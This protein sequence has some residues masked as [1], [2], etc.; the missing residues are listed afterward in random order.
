MLRRKY[1]T[2]SDAE[3]SEREEKRLVK[4]A[5]KKKP[6]RKDTKRNR[7]KDRDNSEKDSD[8][9]QDKKDRSQN[10]KDAQERVVEKYLSRSAVRRVLS[11]ETEKI[12]VK[13]K[14]DGK[15]VQVSEK[16][17]SEESGKYEEIDPEVDETEVDEEP[18]PTEEEKEL[19]EQK[20]KKE[21]REQ[22]KK[23]N[24]ANSLK[25]KFPDVELEEI[26]EVV[27]GKETKEELAELEKMVEEREQEILKDDPKKKTDKILRDTL[28]GVPEY[29]VDQAMKEVLE[30]LE[31]APED[32]DNATSEDLDEIQAQLNSIKRDIDKGVFDLDQTMKTDISD[33]KDAFAETLSPQDIEEAFQSL[34]KGTKEDFR[35]VRRELEKREKKEEKLRQKI[36][37]LEQ[38]KLKNMTQKERDKKKKELEDKKETL[39]RDQYN[40]LVSIAEFEKFL[41]D[42]LERVT[43]LPEEGEEPQDMVKH[44]EAVRARGMSTFENYKNSDSE[45]INSNIRRLKEAIKDMDPGDA[46]TQEVMAMI[47]GLK[48]AEVYAKGQEGKSEETKGVGSATAQIIEWALREG[49]DGLEDLI[50]AEV[51]GSQDP[52]NAKAQQLIH[53]QLQKVV[54]GQWVDL[55]PEDHPA[56]S[57][58]E[59]LADDDPEG[60]GRFLSEQDREWIRQQIQYV[61]GSEIAFADPASVKDDPEAKLGDRNKARAN[62]TGGLVAP[63]PSNYDADQMDQFRADTEK[64]RQDFERA[65]TEPFR[66]MGNENIIDF[67]AE[68][69]RRRKEQEA[70]ME[71]QR[72]EREKAME[73]S[74]GRMARNNFSINSL[75]TNLNDNNTYLG[76]QI[77]RKMSKRQARDFTRAMDEMAT[78]IQKMAR[79]MGIPS[80]VA[81][82]FALRA[83]MISDAI[84]KNANFDA[85]T[86]GE[87]VPGPLEMLDS[88]EPWMD[89]HFTGINGEE[90]YNV[91]ESGGFS[92]AKAAS[93][94]R[95]AR[96]QSKG[97]LAGYEA[98]EDGLEPTRAEKRDPDF[99]EGYNAAKFEQLGQQ[100]FASRRSRRA[101]TSRRRSYRTRR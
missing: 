86:I 71:R 21:E 16:T 23:E 6:P 85:S 9:D 67:Q 72:A 33:L 99:M 34:G 5:P 73:E 8:K 63:D 48:V 56:R 22:K 96:I 77:M 98:F 68:A 26:L 65:V 76:D 39:S 45:T 46:R 42:P 84:E 37:K 11:K 31:I 75:Y 91:Q 87:V 93:R 20:R 62:A 2:L 38:D 69:E 27:T 51:A 78:T 57:L 47:S 53:N 92:N 15:V 101:S 10:F 43:D 28:K 80:K 17:L 74:S 83:D 59:L 79:Q 70:E 60:Q 3:K 29:I 55:I 1:S 89:G 54:D 32:L 50:Y 66:D 49:D 82:D 25:E 94:R 52:A 36:I 41:E 13:R 100:R 61:M 18:E 30:N 90:L 44:E 4:K 7:V 64:F 81:M 40:Q 14:E 97:Y 19:A 88:D 58:A 12:T 24:T 35:K 95:R